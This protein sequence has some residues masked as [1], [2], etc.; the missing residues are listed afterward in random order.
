LKGRVAIIGALALV[1]CENPFIPQSVITRPRVLALRADPPEVAPGESARFTPLVIDPEERTPSFRWFACEP[2]PE[3]SGIDRPVSPC[4]DAQLLADVEA[5]AMTAGVTSLGTSSTAI[6]R[7]P[8]ELD[9]T[10]PLVVHLV[11]VSEIAGTRDLVRKEIT[12][13]G[14]AS[15]RNHNPEIELVVAGG[16][17]REPGDVVGVRQGAILELSA[18]VTATSAE[19]Y[20]RVHPD[21]TKDRAQEDLLF[22]WFT[23]HGRFGTDYKPPVGGILRLLDAA[24]PPMDVSIREGG[25]KSSTDD[26]G[27]KVS[28]NIPLADEDVPP[29]PPSNRPFRV[30]VVVLDKRGGVT[31]AEREVSVR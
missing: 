11:L 9:V 16:R 19:L 3:A 22:S 7:A 12:I 18:I 30:I 20:D 2:M 8:S 15:T 28:L 26:L 29:P 21:G 31:W 6:Y 13:S 5:F 27:F 14:D 17:A 10:K 4:E 1:A 23:E 24:G 25:G